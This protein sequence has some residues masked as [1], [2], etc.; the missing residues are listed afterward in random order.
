MSRF[1][2]RSFLFSAMVFE[3]ALNANARGGGGHSSRSS[4]SH[5]YSNPESVHVRGYTKKDGTYVAPHERSAPND[6]KLDNWSHK[7]NINPNTGEI[8]T[9]ED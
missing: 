5:S 9:K 4:S 1:L 3:V 8:G 7:G 6:T 2:L